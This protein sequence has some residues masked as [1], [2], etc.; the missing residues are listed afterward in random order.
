M[1]YKFKKTILFCSVAVLLLGCNQA[2]PDLSYEGTTTG[3][4]N[5]ETYDETPILVFVNE[6][7]F[8]SVTAT[9]AGF[10]PNDV[11]GAK[12][13]GS[14]SPDNRLKFA[15]SRFYIF[16]FRDGASIDAQGPLSTPVDLRYTLDSSNFTF[17]DYDNA[18]CLVDDARDYS[19]GITAVL[20]N[21]DGGQLKMVTLRNH[22]DGS[23]PDTIPCELFY[24]SRYQDVGYNFFAYYI[25][26]EESVLGNIVH[27]ERDSIWYDFQID[28]TQDIMCGAA[29]KLTP[30]VFNEKY[31]NRNISPTDRSRILNIGGGYSTFAAHRDVHPEV[32]MGHALTQLKFKTYPGDSLC[33]DITINGISIESRNQGRLVVA[34]SDR[35][36]IGFHFNDNKKELFLREFSPDGIQECPPLRQH[37]DDDPTQGYYRMEWDEA[38]MR[39]TSWFDRESMDVGGSLLV[40][41]SDEYKLTIYYTQMRYDERVGAKVPFKLNSIY[42]VKLEHDTM[43][44]SYDPLT[45]KNIFKAGYVYTVKIAVFGISEIKVW[46]SVAGWQNGGDVPLDPDDPDIE[47]NNE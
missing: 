11:P 34:A 5:R 25:D 31:G 39:G 24:S 18:N 41:P 3:V 16:A 47:Y 44:D 28:G 1:I 17:Y 46:V 22:A 14:F 43:S 4:T 32:K 2:Y 8:F 27:R 29:P 12:G 19:K 15:N 7:D 30:E 13:T 9:R 21:D 35:N 20:N 23:A 42:K 10:D 38:T 36:K 26:K 45:G 6:Q 37:P 33:K 40:A